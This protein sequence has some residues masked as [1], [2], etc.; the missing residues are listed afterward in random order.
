MNFGL[1]SSLCILT[2]IVLEKNS[3]IYLYQQKMVFFKIIFFTFFNQHIILEYFDYNIK[4]D[5]MV[6]FKQR[7][8]NT[9]KQIFL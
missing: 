5:F 7:P 4:K 1:S 6:N 2:F 3:E 9:Y 8:D